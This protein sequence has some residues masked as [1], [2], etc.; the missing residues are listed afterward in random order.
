MYSL[1]ALSACILN[2]VTQEGVNV[3]EEAFDNH[4]GPTGIISALVRYRTAYVESPASAIEFSSLRCRSTL[5][6]IL[7]KRGVVHGCDQ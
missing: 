5:R 2:K 6:K 7:G 4:V 3:I 1:P